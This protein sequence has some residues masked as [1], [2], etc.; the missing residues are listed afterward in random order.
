MAETKQR[1]YQAD[2]LDIG[3]SESPA[4]TFMGSGFTALNEEPN[5]QV[6]TKRYIND[7]GATKKVT[8]YEASNPFTADYI[9]TEE[10]INHIAEI[11]K[12]RKTG[13]AAEADY[14]RVDID[15]PVEGSE[16][17]FGARKVRVSIEVSSFSDEDGEY[18]V[19]GNLNE[20]GDVVKGVF[21]TSTKTFSETVEVVEEG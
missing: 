4:I 3:T 8:A 21:N 6:T 7:A 2:Y 1:R 16:N 9:K 13:E 19:E 10:V 12:Y 11:A 20:M 15:D 14:Y 18:Q 5:A 17:T